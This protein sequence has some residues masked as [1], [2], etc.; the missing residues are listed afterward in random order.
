MLATVVWKLSAN[1]LIEQQRFVP[2]RSSPLLSGGAESPGVDRN[3]ALLTALSTASH[4]VGEMR[5][6]PGRQVW[7][8]S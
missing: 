5:F 1:A 7:D 8:G 3:A 4:V 6:Q 2:A